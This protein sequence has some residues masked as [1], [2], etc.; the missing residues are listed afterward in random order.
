MCI[1]LL[2]QNEKRH[3]EED[4]HIQMLLNAMKILK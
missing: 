1:K 2:S 3:I 4:E